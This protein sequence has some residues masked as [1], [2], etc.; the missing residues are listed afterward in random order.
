MTT[1]EPR[2]VILIGI[3]VPL[4]IVLYDYNIV[5]GF[6]FSYMIFVGIVIGVFRFF[7]T[8]NTK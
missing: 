5:L 6:L 2:S 3:I 4:F 1:Q 8:K 7:V